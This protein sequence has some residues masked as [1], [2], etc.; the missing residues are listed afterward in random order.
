MFA[1]NQLYKKIIHLF[2]ISSLFFGQISPMGKTS[3]E[4]REDQAESTQNI[5]LPLSLFERRVVPLASTSAHTLPLLFDQ[6]QG[7]FIIDYQ[8]DNNPVAQ[9]IQTGDMLHFESKD[10]QQYDFL[11]SSPLKTGL[12][13]IATPGSFSFQ[14]PVA[15]KTAD[16]TCKSIEFLDAFSSDEGLRLQVD[17]CDNNSAVTCTDMLFKGNQF[18]AMSGSSLTIHGDTALLSTQGLFND[19]TISC[20]HNA[21]IYTPSFENWGTLRAGNLNFTGEKVLNE[22]SIT[23]DDSFIGQCKDIDH[24]GKL[25]V[26]K[27][28]LFEKVDNLTTT[29]SSLWHVG[30]NWKALV[31]KLYL[32]GNVNV[33]NLALLNIDSHATLNGLFRAPFIHIDSKDLI[34][35]N[36]TTRLFADYY[37]GL[38]AKGWIQYEGNILERFLREN[39]QS[40]A[41]QKN[42]PLLKALP[43]G[44]FLHSE[45]SGIKKSGS[46]VAK[47][48]TVSL[49]A[50]KGLTHTGLTEAGFDADAL[51]VMKAA[52]IDTE[53]ESTLKALNARLNAQNSITQQGDARINNELVIAAPDI[54]Q[55]GSLQAGTLR[56]QGDTISASASSHI[57]VKNAKLEAQERITNAGTVKASEYLDMNAKDIALEKDSHVVSGN[58]KL[59]AQ[60]S[61]T[62]AGTVKASELLVM[63]AQNI[64]LSSDSHIAA[65]NARLKA[66]ETLNNRGIVDAS[67]L[68]LHA[69]YVE[70]AHKITAQDAH[71]K[72]DRYWWNKWGATVTVQNALTIDALASINTFGW[73][74][75]NDL[76]INAGVDLNLLGLYQAK[77]TNI[78]ALIALNAGL[79]AP[80]IDSYRDVFNTDNAW[81]VG[82]GLLTTFVPQAGL[83]LGVCRN[84]KDLYNQEGIYRDVPELYH[85]AR[86]LYAQE[87]A[88][89]SDWISVICGAKKVATSAAQT[90]KITYDVG[91]MA[92]Q[93]G[94]AGYAWYN[95]ENADTGSLVP[96]K[97]GEESKQTSDNAEKEIS[98]EQTN[99]TK[100]SL[101]DLAWEKVY[102]AGDA[103]RDPKTWEHAGWQTAS[104]VA[105]VCGPQ[106]NRDTLVDF[107]GGIILGVNGHS[108]SIWNVN[109]GVSA[110]AHRNTV[111]TYYGTNFG[112]MVAGSLNIHAAKNYT[113][114]GAIN[115]I[116]AHITAENLNVDGKVYVTNEVA[117]E[118]KNKASVGADINAHDVNIQAQEAVLKSGGH[119]A[120]RG[121]A[122][123]IIADNITNQAVL[124]G[125]RVQVLGKVVELQNGSDIRAQGGDDTVIIKA[126]ESLKL[127]AG[128]AMAASDISIETASLQGDAGNTITSTN[129]T[130]VKTKS[131]NNQG[132]INGN[133]VADFTGD[134][135]QLKSIGH[136]DRMQYR[137]TLANDLADRLVEGN[138]D[139][140]RVSDIGDVTVLAG[141]QDV[142]LKDEH[143]VAHSYRVVSDGNISAD[144]ALSSGGSIGL[145]AGKN[146]THKNMDAS[147]SVDMSA[148]ENII[149]QSTVSRTVNGNNYQDNLERVTVRADN[150]VN[151]RAD[152]NIV[153]EAATVQSGKGGTH[154]R[155]GE[156][157]VAGAK[158]VQKHTQSRTRN[159]KKGVTRSH[160]DTVTKTEVSEYTSTGD[161]TMHAGDTCDLHAT[162]ISAPGVKSVYGKNGVN[163]QAVY[164]VHEHT[165]D[166]KKDGGWL[167]TS[168]TEDKKPGSKTAKV[169]DFKGGS[170]PEISSDVKIDMPFT[171][172]SKKIV[173]NAPELNIRVAESQKEFVSNSSTEN[174]VWWSKGAKKTKD[175]TYSPTFKGTIETNA[176]KVSIDS[177]EDG[178]P[179]SVKTT[180]GNATFSYNML[181]EIHEHQ[182]ISA[183]GPTKAASIII[184]M[185]VTMATAGYATTLGASLAATLGIQSA[186]ATAMVTNM[187]AATLTSLCVQSTDAFVRNK[188]DIFATGREI[189]S[190]QTIK[191]LVITAVSAGAMAGVE[192]VIFNGLPAVSQANNLSELAA[193]TIPRES[194]NATIRTIAGIAGGQKIEDAV[195]DNVRS[196]AANT[197]GK[198]GAS[199]IGN[200]YH[201]GYIDPVIHKGLH[202]GVGAVSGA[203]AGGGRGAIAG[204]MG[205]VVAETVADTFA[206]KK[207]S[208][209]RM[210]K[211]EQAAGHKFTQEEFVY[212]WNNQA[213]AYMQRAATHA[214]I[215]KLTAASIA[216]LA[217]QDVDIASNTGA[218]AIDNNFFGLGLI[219]LGIVAGSAA[220]SAYNIYDA[221]CEGGTDAA[222]QQLGIEIF[223]E[224]VALATG[225]VVGK[226]AYR[227]GTKIYPTVKGAIN[228]AFEAKPGLKIA[229][230]KFGN[231]L[232]HGAEKFGNTVVGKHLQQA[233]RW[234]LELPGKLGQKLD[235]SINGLSEGLASVHVPGSVAAKMEAQAA[236]GLMPAT[237]AGRRA[238]RSGRGYLK[239]YKPGKITPP[240]TTLNRSGVGKHS[241]LIDSPKVT[242]VEDL[243]KAGRPGRETGGVST[244]YEFK[245]GFKKASEHFDLLKPKN[246]RDISNNG[247]Q[248]KMGYLNDGRK[249]ILREKNSKGLQYNEIPTLEI[250][251][252]GNPQ[253]TKFRYFDQ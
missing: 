9:L 192:G 50:K 11:L 219:G 64:A 147:D 56:A 237:Q 153:H 149:A 113:S 247:I 17:Y 38:K 172:D 138:G 155:A 40:N 231:K 195:P 166:Y 8:L 116:T 252:D 165:S 93:A 1:I 14:K 244:Q 73:L 212:H 245:G 243:V 79:L 59:E 206:A 119:V 120:A 76:T 10:P 81:R 49:D 77:R 124:S 246:V 196:F 233:D 41:I 52:S 170:A 183:Q 36:F 75:A 134:E 46:I 174:L 221:Y 234:A 23:I 112:A 135:S 203:I 61:I 16:F 97:E 249:V 102:A 227:F 148:G 115:G 26:A 2:V 122:T 205:A 85:R 127:G 171:S 201:K 66:G 65:G 44:V 157:I 84:V 181:K 34:T 58:A 137:G 186:T 143:D 39:A 251:I 94:K 106:I 114:T 182:K 211:L 86:T 18:N 202:A 7:M 42:N 45:Q 129:H 130:Y 184:A 144:K 225:A 160:K 217:R 158:T 78:N 141:N 21:V 248:K 209:E 53:K 162:T 55:H 176:K 32:D 168:K 83:A 47:N 96:E 110:Y 142:H 15:V 74:Q 48:G 98:T 152:C 236:H 240:T 180:D 229:L 175:V 198:A 215:A 178:A 5:P 150:A 151:M 207:P 43:R 241:K 99:D 139:L 24:R 188:G 126:D 89:A 154:M 82:E 167:G 25:Q 6:P 250:Q 125:K 204:A 104:M 3:A 31:T 228:A 253:K 111:D 100:Q 191:N 197:I 235:N 132:S 222:I 163:G 60:A 80:K 230:G 136:V 185:A 70:N 133:L 118:A 54:T 226:V 109:G 63:D 193:F 117:L 101:S 223:H 145:H 238:V 72:A 161:I 51:L 159:K 13:K 164:E 179:W 107:N 12:F 68:L 131:L 194:A 177:V 35:C 220:Y 90:A 71:I 173:F 69:K 190:T 214:D 232:M 105:S 87:D 146:V 4:D 210:L 123:N 95:G 91:K 67:A 62:N 213:Q 189:A 37:I 28:C 103:V 88:G 22:G 200:A 92:Y 128:S 108:C 224:G 30:G 121:G 33:G 218:T 140:L 169:V 239:A 199:Q 29:R 242:T 19:G 216:M 208:L 156:K 27:D 57:N 20:A 187:T